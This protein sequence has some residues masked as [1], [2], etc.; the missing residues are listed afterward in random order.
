[1]CVSRDP[2]EVDT[3]EDKKKKKIA[4]QMVDIDLGLS[5]YAN[6]RK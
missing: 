1:M 4:K 6:A 3:E 2:D 5:A